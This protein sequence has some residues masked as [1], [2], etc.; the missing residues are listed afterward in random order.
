M[1]WFDG[2]KRGWYYK[3][4]VENPL[5][6]LKEELILET[7]PQECGLTETLMVHISEIGTWEEPKEKKKMAQTQE[8]V[9]RRRAAAT[10]TAAKAYGAFTRLVT[11][12]EATSEDR[13][14]ISYL[15]NYIASVSNDESVTNG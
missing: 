8:Q 2:F 1:S 15:S 7:T 3:E 12:R 13:V 5:T 6:N 11:H 9:D 4:L 14:L 10:E